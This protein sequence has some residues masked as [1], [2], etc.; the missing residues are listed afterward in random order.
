M[1]SLLE[2]YIYIYIYTHTRSS[3]VKFIALHCY[4]VC[5]T[6]NDV[7]INQPLRPTS[8][9]VFCIF[10]KSQNAARVH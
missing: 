8:R 9:R 2:I 3:Y 4:G 6:D 7:K 10:N 5:E 1:V